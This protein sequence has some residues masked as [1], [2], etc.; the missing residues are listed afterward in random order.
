MN[1]K[2]EISNLCFSVFIFGLFLFVYSGCDRSQQIVLYT[3]VDEPVAA[4]IIRDF[5]KQT[6]ISVRLVTDTEAT[7]SVGLVERIRAEKANPQADVW[8]GNEPFRTI[9]LAEEGL[10]QP[11]DSPSAADVIS[12]YKDPQHRW[13]GNGLRARVIAGYKD[14][15]PNSVNDLTGSQ[16]KGH[17]AMATPTAGTTGGH[18][19]AL[20]VLWGQAKADAYFHALHDNGMQLLGGNGPVAEA[21][22][23]GTMLA[24][25]TDNDDAAN[26]QSEISPTIS[27]SLPDQD[28]I[29]TLMIPTTVGLAS[30]SKQVEASRKLIDYLLSDK[31][32]QKLIDAKFAGWTVRRNNEV[33]AMQVDYNQVARML[34]QAI[35]RATDILQGRE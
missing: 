3:S 28:T 17:I 16:F 10:L 19:A 7:K 32:E 22:C 34:P 9:L 12:M 15:K 20:Y 27:A 6:G 11:F 5:E 4:P 26:A 35:R 2:A 29:G 1:F 24:G 33:K 8:W 30:G 25:L 14:L 31:V 23:R 21:V 18:V 13:A